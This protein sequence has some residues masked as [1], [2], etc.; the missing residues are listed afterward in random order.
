M[1]DVAETSLRN[2]KRGRSNHAGRNA[3]YPYYAAYSPEFVEDSIDFA[4]RR[5]GISRILDPWNGS[6]T[7]TQIALLRD[8]SAEGYDLNPAMVIVAKARTLPS[9]VAPSVTSLLDDIS[10]KAMPL[11]QQ[12]CDD[13]LASWLSPKSASYVRAI[14][15]ATFR[16]LVDRCREGLVA[17]F[18]SLDAVSSLAAFFYVAQFRVLRG[19]LRSFNASNPTWIRRPSPGELVDF[20]WGDVLR[21]FRRNVDWMYGKLRD[22]IVS[23]TSF[24]SVATI[25]VGNSGALPVGPGSFST[26]I[27]SPP[28]C[29]R[30]DYAIKTS[31]EL[32]LLGYAGDSFRRLRDAMIGTPTICGSPKSSSSDWG[33]KCTRLLRSIWRNQAK[34]SK[35]YY[36]KTYVQYFDGLFRSLSE[37]AR[38]L[39]NSGMCFLVLQ[40]SHY[41]ELHVDLAGITTEMAAFWG[42]DLVNRTDFRTTR[43]MLG[44]NTSSRIYNQVSAR[45]ESIVVLRKHV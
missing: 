28:Y 24:S 14:E 27:S 20:S 22:D 19:M 34:A 4:R 38:A 43:T 39:R 45:T 29:T 5:G 9:N 12:S 17:E 31:P 13:P 42:L 2:P 44:V 8:I 10:Q 25:D 30:I 3:W 32:A 1:H 26:V 11:I 21:L 35:S 6:G 15:R 36:W 18:A 37:I 40:D 41:K 23:P 16:L 33:K 7:T